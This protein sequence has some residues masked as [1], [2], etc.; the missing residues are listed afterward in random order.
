[1]VLRVHKEHTEVLST[2]LSLPELFILSGK[3]YQPRPEPKGR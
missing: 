3:L 1:M 2:L